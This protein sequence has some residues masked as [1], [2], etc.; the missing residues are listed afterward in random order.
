MWATTPQAN[1]RH[2]HAYVFLG[3]FDVFYRHGRNRNE[4]R[5]S[6]SLRALVA[7]G[8]SSVRRIVLRESRSFYIQSDLDYASMRRFLKHSR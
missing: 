2:V 5:I 4:Q 7:A 3:T 8:L 6:E 1:R